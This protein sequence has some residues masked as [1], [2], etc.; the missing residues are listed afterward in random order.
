MFAD[1][2]T[3]SCAAKNLDEASASLQTIVNKTVNCQMLSQQNFALTDNEIFR[4]NLLTIDTTDLTSPPS[5][6]LKI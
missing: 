2:I 6:N 5:L 1:D 3:I 4:Y